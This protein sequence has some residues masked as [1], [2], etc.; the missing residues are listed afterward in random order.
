MFMMKIYG[1]MNLWMIFKLLL[2]PKLV[3]IEWN[4]ASSLNS[5]I[6]VAAGLVYAGGS[7]GSSFISGYNGCVAITSDS[8]RTPR[9]DSNNNQCFDGTT[10]ITCSYHYSGYIF[11]DTIM[12][13]GQ[14]Y[15]WTTERGI[16]V[17]GMPTYD[18]NGTMTGNSGNGYAK[19]TYL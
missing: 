6:M 14:G 8:D 5:R 7:G 17:V 4:N 13:D 1:F 15:K 12:I 18:G 9:L 10:D 3:I 11:T 2:H 19:I 16:E